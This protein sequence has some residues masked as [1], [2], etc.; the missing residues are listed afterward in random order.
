MEFEWTSSNPVGVGPSPF[1]KSSSKKRS[2]IDAMAHE[3]YDEF[4]NEFDPDISGPILKRQ[5]LSR[6]TETEN[7]LQA[8]LNLIYNR[9]LNALDR[10]Q[11]MVTIDMKQYDPNIKRLVVMK[12]LTKFSIV[13][14][15]N[16]TSI[17]L[18]NTTP[19]EFVTYAATTCESM[20]I[21]LEPTSTGCPTYIS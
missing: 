16:D 7:T 10:G 18:H 2:Y 8:A 13:V 6:E 4:P 14:E 1:P 21:D 17:D 11:S 3:C 12:I 15:A 19:L 9:Y 20:E 5:R